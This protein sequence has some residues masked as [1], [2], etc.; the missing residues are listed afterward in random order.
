MVESIYEGQLA[1]ISGI[2][3]LPGI[4]LFGTINVP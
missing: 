2:W 1:I 3:E 4:V